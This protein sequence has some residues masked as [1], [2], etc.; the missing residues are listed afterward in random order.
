MVVA[1]ET[2]ERLVSDPEQPIE[3]IMM[4]VYAIGVDALLNALFDD[5][6]RVQH[7][8]PDRAYAC[9]RVMDRIWEQ[10]GYR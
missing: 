4:E 3:T 5:G 2:I 7:Q 6:W 10:T 9:M 1:P 8:D